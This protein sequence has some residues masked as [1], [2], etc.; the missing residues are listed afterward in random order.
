MILLHRRNVAAECRR[1]RITRLLHSTNLYR[2]LPQI[3]ET[4]ELQTARGLIE[5]YG[6]E[7]AKRFLHDPCRYEQFAVGLD[8]LNASLTVPNYELL[9]HRSKADWRAEW[10]HLALP[11]SLLERS[12]TLFCPVSAAKEK[13]RFVQGGLGGFVAMFAPEVDGRNREGLLRDVP[14][15]PQAEVLLRGPLPLADVAAVIVADQQ[16][17]TEIE[18]LCEHYSRTIRVEVAPHLFAWPERLVKK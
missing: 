12:D 9:Y 11:P 3:L 7:G 1:R 2:N 18:R 10:V 8:Y 4:G 13:G 16:T 17:G 5:R 15:H 6:H 14:T